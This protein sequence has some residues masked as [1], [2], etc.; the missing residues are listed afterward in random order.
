VQLLLTSFIIDEVIGSVVS[1][2]ASQTIVFDFH[3]HY[4]AVEDSTNNVTSGVNLTIGGNP[5]TYS[6]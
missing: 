5:A 1:I 4:F 6:N 3:Q 2:G